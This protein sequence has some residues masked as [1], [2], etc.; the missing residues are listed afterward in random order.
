MIYANLAVAKLG[1]LIGK[2]GCTIAF[3]GYAMVRWASGNSGIQMDPPGKY[4][5]RKGN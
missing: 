5:D 2:F 1:L 3:C 4:F